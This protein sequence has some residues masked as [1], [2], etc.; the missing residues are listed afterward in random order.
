[1]WLLIFGELKY[2]PKVLKYMRQGRTMTQG[3]MP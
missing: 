3:F 2:I 1:M